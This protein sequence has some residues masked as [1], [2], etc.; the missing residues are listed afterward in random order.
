MSARKLRLAGQAAFGL[1]E[2][3]VA[4]AI[5]LVLTAATLTLY[6]DMT[7]S[8]T[9][10]ARTN[11]QMENGR[12]AIQLLR[13]DLQH[14]GFWNG[15][16]PEFDDLTAEDIPGDYPLAIPAPCAAYSAW[17][18]N[19]TH[20]TNLVGL[21]VDLYSA[22]PAGCSDQLA[23][24]QP[25]SDVLVVRYAQGC[26]AGTAGSACASQ[27]PL[28]TELFWQTSHC[29]SDAVRYVLTQGNSGSVVFKRDC[30]TG[31]DKRKFI[32]NIYYLRDYA[33]TPGD[34][35]PTLMQSSFDLEG[36]SLVQRDAVP[37]IEG[38]EAMRFEF[39]I[40]NLSDTGA[41][42][43]HAGAIV[44]ANEQMRN[45]PTNRGDG[46]ADTTCNSTSG[47]DL[48]ALVN[49]VVVQVHLLVRNLE[50]TPGYVSD[51]E[52]VLAGQTYGPFGDN[53]QRHVYSTTVRLNN[54]SGRRETP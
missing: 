40:D 28:G 8:S 13:D 53:F 45:S 19:A 26:V 54:I 43:N 15:F 6:L 50:P 34:G 41:A 33:V 29:E 31:A 10:L 47:C 12:L 46:A 2:L 3:M 16:V 27:N 7:R 39:G 44:W 25:D 22:V 21:P 4:M 5:G 49:T 1:I 14:A 9:E 20:R 51:K 36:G 24:K 52:Y 30:A 42:V 37:M 23:S 11:M 48:D 17:S 32:N 38:I 18:A 35:I